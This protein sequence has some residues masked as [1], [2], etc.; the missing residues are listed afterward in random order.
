MRTISFSQARSALKEVLD[1]VADDADVTIITR[2]DA[3]DA[4]VMSLATF[5]SWQ[6]TMHL[7]SSPANAR[8][9]MRSIAELR[10]GRARARAL[11][12][13]PAQDRVREP[14]SSYSTTRKAAGARRKSAKRQTRG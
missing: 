5:N 4:V 14:R 1:R 12:E 6:E 2:R 10:G 7:L 11:I 9:L 8:H 3:A 13:P